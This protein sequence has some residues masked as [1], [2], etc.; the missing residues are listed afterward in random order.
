MALPDL[1]AVGEFLEPIALKERMI[2]QELKKPV[3]HAYFVESGLISLRLV[4]A[5]SMLETAV[6]GSRGVIGA[7][8]LLG[9]HLPTHQSVVLFPGNALRI[10]IDDLR[11]VMS[12]RPGIQER[13]SRYVQ[14]LTQHSAQTGLCGVRHGLEQ[15]LASWICL[16]CDA[17]DGGALPIT[18]EYFSTALGLHRSG[19][20][21][22]LLRFERMGLIRKM[23]GVLHVD[24]RERLERV[25]CNCCGIIANAYTAAEA[26]IAVHQ[27]ELASC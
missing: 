27:Q 1:A 7:S 16:T 25:A 13:L 12:D 8:F 20:T 3:E 14:A 19:V 10:A 24:D 17:T 6:V 15:R 4:A 5:G 11:R 9:G 22:T 18:H 21:R 26:P 2:V 23:R